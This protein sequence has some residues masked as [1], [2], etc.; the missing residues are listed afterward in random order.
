M[1]EAT[2]ISLYGFMIQFIGLV[3]ELLRYN[4]TVESYHN[5]NHYGRWCTQSGAQANS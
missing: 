5:Y 3:I 1:I 4:H 2:L